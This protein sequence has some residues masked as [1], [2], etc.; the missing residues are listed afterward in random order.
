MSDTAPR[1][2]VLGLG[3]V[4]VGDDAFG[5]WVV[6][7]L[8]ARYALD[9][10]VTCIEGTP[11][12]DLV[13]HLMGAAAVIIVDTVSSA[14]EPGELRLYRRGDMFNAPPPPRV[15]PH[16]PG[17]HE[18]LFTLE[19]LGMAPK[20]VLLV[21]VVPALVRTGIG[22]TDEV[23]G[24]VDRAV[25]EVAWELARL[26]HAPTRRTAMEMPAIWW[27]GVTSG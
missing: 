10:D 2:V 6:R 19:L 14:G 12:A 16:E 25:E 5:P 27:E 26:G 21:G 3:N 13:P 15:N 11:G 8:E 4:L 9:G 24:A 7:T 20:D 18:A 22:M 17:F 1:T 23:Q